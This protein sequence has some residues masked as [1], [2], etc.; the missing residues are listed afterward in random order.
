MNQPNFWD[1][2]DKANKT[3]QELTNLKREIT[4]YK[5]NEKDLKYSKE[6]TFNLHL[7]P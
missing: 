2:V 1:D 4:S 5:K 3:N 6:K 7:F